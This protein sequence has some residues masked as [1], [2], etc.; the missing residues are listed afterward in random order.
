MKSFPFFSFVEISCWKG[1]CE[2]KILFIFYSL[3]STEMAKIMKK[4]ANKNGGELAIFLQNI[5]SRFTITFKKVQ[6]ASSAWK[7]LRICCYDP[8]IGKVSTKFNL[9]CFYWVKVLFIIDFCEN[10]SSH[11]MWVCFRIAIS[12]NCFILITKYFDE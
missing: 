11:W 9:N 2:D 5:F 10:D 8:S 7:F 12:I 4:I 3:C 1:R 6:F